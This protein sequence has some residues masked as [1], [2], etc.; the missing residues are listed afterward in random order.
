MWQKMPLS[1]NAEVSLMGTQI[2]LY[3]AAAPFFEGDI[4]LEALF[5][6]H[7]VCAKVT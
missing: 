2:I 4:I 5:G 3:L 7:N 1:R 6:V